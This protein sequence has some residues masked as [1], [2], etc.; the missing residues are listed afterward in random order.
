MQ[1]WGVKPNQLS[2][3]TIMDAYAR[4]GNVNNVIKIYNFMQVRAGP[5]STGSK[6]A[7]FC[8]ATA[9]SPRLWWHPLGSHQRLMRLQFLG[10]ACALPLLAR[11]TY[12]APAFST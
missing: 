5:P 12:C 11:P 1:A 2:F 3:N 8:C 6:P 4:E 7:V 10:S 9:S